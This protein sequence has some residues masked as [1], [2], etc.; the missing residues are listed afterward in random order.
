MRWLVDVGRRRVVAI[1]SLLGYDAGCRAYVVCRMVSHIC[2]AARI[3][4]SGRARNG[5]D[6]GLQ[7]NFSVQQLA[8][9]DTSY[10]R[11]TVFRST[12]T[13]N[14]TLI[15]SLRISHRLLCAVKF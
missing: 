8:T 11:T 12:P 15:H 7:G 5:S 2:L 1:A 10:C 6:T 3:F 14:S 9:L 4:T 13:C